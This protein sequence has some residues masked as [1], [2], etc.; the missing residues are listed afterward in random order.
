M[1]PISQM[2]D[3]TKG[4]MHGSQQ[5]YGKDIHLNPNDGSNHYFMVFRQSG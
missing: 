3:F 4:L 2:L 1:F 5:I